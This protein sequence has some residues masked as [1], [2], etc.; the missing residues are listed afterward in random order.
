MVELLSADPG[1]GQEITEIHVW[2][3]TYPNG[4][5]GLIGFATGVA[6][7]GH[8]HVAALMSTDRGVAERMAPLARQIQGMAMQSA[9][10]LTRVKLVTFRR[11]PGG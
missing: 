9:D 7:S 5:Q 10:K 8:A 1:R 2:V 4:G 3:C 6:S 11:V